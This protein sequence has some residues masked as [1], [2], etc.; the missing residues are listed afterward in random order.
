MIS[1]LSE[2]ERAIEP[3]VRPGHDKAIQDFKRSCRE[4]LNGLCWEAIELTKLEP[5]ESLNSHAVDLAEKL[6]YEP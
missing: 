5:G 3:H 4:R 6:A 1:L 2:F